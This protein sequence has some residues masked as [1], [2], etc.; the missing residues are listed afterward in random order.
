MTDFTGTVFTETEII[1]MALD[2]GI[3]DDLL[4]DTTDN[5]YDWLPQNCHVVQ[6]FYELSCELYAR[7]KRPY[8]S[9][10]CIR[11]KLRWDSMV[12][13]VGTEYKISNN[14]TPHLAR[15]IMKLDSK[16]DG[17]FKLKATA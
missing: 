1:D 8:Y 7:G 2:D 15:F 10:Y 9:A 11:E 16:L 3:F 14:V 4:E 6:A 17:M 12:S 5:F 13:E